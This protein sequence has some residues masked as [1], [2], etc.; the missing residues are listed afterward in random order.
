MRDTT[1]P[2]VRV[3]AEFKTSSGRYRSGPPTAPAGHGRTSRRI[4]VELSGMPFD[5]TY[6]IADDTIAIG[7]LIRVPGSGSGFI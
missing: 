4:V 2:P 5:P 1:L 6:E 3:E 7:D